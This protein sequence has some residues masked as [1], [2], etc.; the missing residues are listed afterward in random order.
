MRNKLFIVMLAGA[1]ALALPGCETGEARIAQLESAESNTPLPVEVAMP[2]IA[3]LY[4]TYQTTAALAADREA[5]IPSRVAGEVVEILVEE[6]ETVAAG[7]ALARLDGDRLRLE[8]LEAKARFEMTARE[9]ARA[10]RLRER[11]LVSAAAAEALKFDLD[12]LEAA[13]EMKRLDYE[14]TTIRA[15]IPGVISVRH[16][17]LGWRLEAGEPAFSIADTDR[18]VAELHI[19]QR[20]LGR[21]A[22]GLE[23]RLRVD[24]MPGDDFYAPIDRVSPTIDAADGSFRA[25]VYIDN[26][27]GLLAPGMF[28][29]FSIAYEKHADALTV[30]SSAIIREDNEDVVYVVQDGTASRRAVRIGIEGGGMTEILNGLAAG[31]PVI[32]TGQSS[33][34][35]GSRV[36][37]SD[38]PGIAG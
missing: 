37:A 15:T 29:R 5:L 17:K 34:R 2:R 14:Y 27:K 18:L 4:A 13:Y 1:T 22:G 24:A 10:R 28:G 38:R 26:E 3:D 9:Y 12:A 25:T 36:L 23:A 8:M 20:E 19:P 16:I 32:V 33:L 31:E 6:G 30:P 35:D 7:Q 11:G 21:I